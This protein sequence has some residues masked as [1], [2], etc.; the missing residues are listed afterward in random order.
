MIRSE[1]RREK[2]KKSKKTAELTKEELDAYYR[3]F[4]EVAKKLWPKEEKPS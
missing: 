3:Y 1:L 2:M 4:Q